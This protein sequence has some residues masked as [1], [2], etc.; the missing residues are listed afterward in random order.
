MRTVLMLC[1]HEPTM[2]PRIRWEAEGAADRFEIT[3]LGFNRTDAPLPAAE[4]GAGYEIRRIVQRRA[5]AAEFLFRLWQ[6]CGFAARPGSLVVLLLL[7]P[8]VLLAAVV[9][10]LGPFLYRLMR[11]WLPARLVTAMQRSPAVHLYGLLRGEF[12]P[13]TLLFWSYIAGLPRKP[14]VVHCNDLQTLL[15]GVLARKR[16]GCRC[17][18]DAHEYFP[19]SNPEGGWLERTALHLLE[20]TLVHRAHAVVTVNY[21]LAE[22]MARAYG[23]AQVHSVPNAEPRAQGAL[24]ALRSPMTGLAAGRVKFLFQG[25]FSPG[26]GIEELIAAWAKL[27][28][29]VAAALFLRGPGNCWRDDLMA[30]AGRLGVL[31]RSVYFLD[32]VTE[33]A[34]VAAS[35]EADVGVIP[36]K[37]EIE[38]YRYACPNKLSQ[39][40]HAGL[41]VLTND[42]PYVREVLED[43]QAGLHYSS[44]NPQSLLAA[45]NLI[46]GDPACLQRGRRNALRYAREKFHWQAFSGTLYALY[47]DACAGAA[48]SVSRTASSSAC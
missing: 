33:D 44:D 32:P 6:A 38:G 24:Q 46:A 11:A 25:Q 47:E 7:L 48:T 23:L 3:V 20:K 42:L 41:M 2:D 5:S 19:R 10:P 40:L 31:G 22:V 36:Y 26:R 37:G 9:L 18:Y 35:A 4:R 27:D 16:F 28:P 17:V 34:L 21:Q 15:V 43:A 14:D 39:Y 30:L 1:A 8:V 45:V 29:A 12:A 13:A